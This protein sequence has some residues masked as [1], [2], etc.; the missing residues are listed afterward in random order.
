[1]TWQCRVGLASLGSDAIVPAGVGVLHEAS[2][3]LKELREGHLA[4][5]V[6][7]VVEQS[8][9]PQSR[10]LSE[11]DTMDAGQTLFRGVQRLQVVL[12]PA[13]AVAPGLVAVVDPTEIMCTCRQ[14]TWTS[15]K[16]GFFTL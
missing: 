12:L 13:V 11:Q 7:S 14:E 3:I 5:L 10:V 8:G 6:D 4:S 2:Q 15:Y 9:T 1:M 16:D